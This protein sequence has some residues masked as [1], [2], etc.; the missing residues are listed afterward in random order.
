[1]LF[2]DFCKR[3]KIK[4]I[5]NKYILLFSI[6]QL[7]VEKKK[8]TFLSAARPSLALSDADDLFVESVVGLGILCYF[9]F[10]VSLIVEFEKRGFKIKK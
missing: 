8:N 5:K 7:Q 6:S 2:G 1:L 9:L 3:K 4:V 10:A